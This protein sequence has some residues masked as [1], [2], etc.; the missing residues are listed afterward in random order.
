MVLGA[1]NDPG[2]KKVLASGLQWTYNDGP[3]D[4]Y[5]I[6]KRKRAIEAEFGPWTA[7]N[8]PLGHGI[9]SNPEY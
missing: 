1:G 5:G 2:P 3:M 6:R 4:E 9:D 8:I 7:Q